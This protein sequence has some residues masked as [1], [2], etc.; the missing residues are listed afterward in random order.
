MSYAH[1][2]NLYQDQRILAFKQCFALE[3]VH[4]TSV[5]VG[6][7]NAHGPHL[8]FFSGGADAVEF[9]QIFD[10]P[11]LLARF[12]ALGHP[13]VVVY[14]EAYGGK[15]Q[16]MRKTYGSELKFIAFEVK[17]GSEPATW[18]AV[19]NA[20]DVVQK[21]GLEFVPFEAIGTSLAEI[22][23]QRDLPSRVALRRGIAEPRMSEGIVL[24]P[25]FEVRASNGDRIV[26]KHKTEQFRETRSPRPVI[27]PARQVVL[28]AAEAIAFEWA[29]PMRL[30]HVL[31]KLTPPA[32]NMADIPRVIAAMQADIEREAA[33]EISYG[34]AA[35]KAIAT[36]TVK[37]YSAKNKSKLED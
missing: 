20:L 4:G 32:A 7:T 31:D 27:D 19:P 1:I 24:R 11:D 5:H 12:V 10:E 9:R 3:K 29:T 33:S 13:H 17:I 28:D 15:Q 2:P 30:E 14:G 16:G 18:L 8:F 23:A 36:A 25:P 37:L 35:A 34:S 26:A 6:F 21:L 22:D